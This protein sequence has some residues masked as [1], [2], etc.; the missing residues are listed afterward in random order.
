MSIPLFST[1]ASSV[2]LWQKCCWI[3][4]GTPRSSKADSHQHI[5]M[6]T[7]GG[8]SICCQIWVTPLPAWRPGIWSQVEKGPSMLGAWE[9]Y[10]RRQIQTAL[11]ILNLDNLLPPCQVCT[12]GEW[13][14]LT[15]VPFWT[16][17]VWVKSP[18]L[19]ADQ[20]EALWS[21]TKE[22]HLGR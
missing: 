17:P 7:M 5:C 14:Y 15:H 8:L 13:K 9:R 2:L 18:K 22:A 21:Q 3:L 19:L 4:S 6:L 12:K 1:F 16:R 11:K 10:S 20:A